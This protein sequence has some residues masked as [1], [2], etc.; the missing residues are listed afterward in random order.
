MRLRPIQP[1]Y[2]FDDLDEIDESNFIADPNTQRI[3]EPSI[4]DD[5]LPALLDA[6]GIVSPDS[7]Q[8]TTNIVA[9]GLRA[10][11]VLRPNMSRNQYQFASFQPLETGSRLHLLRIWDQHH[12]PRR[13]LHQYH[14]YSAL[15][16]HLT[17][18]AHVRKLLRS[19]LLI[20]LQLKALTQ[21]HHQVILVN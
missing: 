9:F 5:A 12:T 16:V 8:T 19:S 11:P 1:K 13:I 6:S 14:P 20:H 7:A 18:S 2:H 17:G 10:A 4:T 21:H 3:S 15:L